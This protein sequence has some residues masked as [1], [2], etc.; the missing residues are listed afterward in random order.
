MNSLLED[1]VSDEKLVKDQSKLFDITDANLFDDDTDFS[2]LSLHDLVLNES[3]D[4]PPLSNTTTSPSQEA[5]HATPEVENTSDLDAE[6]IKPNTDCT[7]LTVMSSNKLIL[8]T[9]NR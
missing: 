3:D 5:D 8:A 9:H 1:T 6:E 2:D 4:T 7:A